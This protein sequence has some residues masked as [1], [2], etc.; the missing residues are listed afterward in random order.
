MPYIPHSEMHATGHTATTSGIMILGPIIFVIAIVL[1]TLIFFGAIYVYFRYFPAMFSPVPKRYTP[2]YI[3]D[4]SV[5]PIPPKP[6]EYHR[7]NVKSFAHALETPTEK[8]H[9]ETT[10]KNGLPEP[11][12]DIDDVL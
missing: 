3:H 6:P 11:K 8:L 9:I 2:T 5:I 10:R 7:P 1:G 12:L 4:D